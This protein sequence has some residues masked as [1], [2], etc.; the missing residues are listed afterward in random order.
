MFSGI[1]QLFWLVSPHDGGKRTRAGR[2]FLPAVSINHFGCE[3]FRPALANIT[4]AIFPF[5]LKNH[6]T[7][8]KRSHGQVKPVKEK[9]NGVTQA[10]DSILSNEKAV[11]PSL[12]LLF[13]S[14]VHSS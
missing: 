7:M 5:T 12:A 1:V 6:I 11:D 8:G 2:T 10:Q 14:S 9:S 13:A 3:F 4:V